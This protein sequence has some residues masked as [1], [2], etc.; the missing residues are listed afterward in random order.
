MRVIDINYNIAMLKEAL[1][2]TFAPERM[3]P[4]TEEIMEAQGFIPHTMRKRWSWKDQRVL[5]NFFKELA[6]GKVHMH[7]KNAHVFISCQV[8]DGTRT[9]AEVRCMVLHYYK[10]L[11]KASG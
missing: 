5:E 8:M 10:V 3:L 11:N 7:N 2:F 9:P 1:G 4:Y 6:Q